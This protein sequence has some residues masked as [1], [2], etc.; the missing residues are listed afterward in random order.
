MI[1]GGYSTGNSLPA[2]PAF[3]DNWGRNFAPL[4]SFYLQSER[5]VRAVFFAVCIISLWLCICWPVAAGLY[6][7]TI[8]PG[9]V[10]WP[11]GMVPYVF[12]SALSAAQQ[13]TYLNGL[14]DWELA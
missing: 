14:R 13:Q 4:K 7:N 12:D 11:N 8:S 2:F 9:N 5:T 10:P 6:V 1:V 3:S